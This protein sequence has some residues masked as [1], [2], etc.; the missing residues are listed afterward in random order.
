MR[1]VGAGLRLL[2]R[3]DPALAARIVPVFVTV[4]PARDTPAVLKEFVTAF[5]P[6]MI[7]LTGSPAAI[8]AAQ[9]AYAVYAKKGETSA[10]GGYLMDHQNSVFLMDPA[11]QP[12]ALIPADEGPQAVADE[13]AKWAR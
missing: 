10:G 2:E 11:G 4:D 3:T 8:A 5:H 9:K 13:I 12:L 6:R 7:G 1:N